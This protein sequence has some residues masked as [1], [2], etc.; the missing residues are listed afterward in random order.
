ME[1]GF[2][3]RLM[4][5]TEPDHVEI[6]VSDEVVGTVVRISINRGEYEFRA[7]HIGK[8]KLIDERDGRLTDRNKTMK[9]TENGFAIYTEFQDANDKSIRVQTSSSAEKRMVWIHTEPGEAHLT[10]KTARQVIRALQSFVDG[11]D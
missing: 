7:C 2:T 9:R 5:I 10:V 4:D 8:L 11:K 6:R 1:V 3:K